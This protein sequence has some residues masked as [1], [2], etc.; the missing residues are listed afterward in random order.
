MIPFML[1]SSF[2]CVCVS[3]FVK[4][5]FS[6]SLFPSQVRALWRSLW[7]ILWGLLFCGP[8]PSAS[9]PGG[10]TLIRSHPSSAGPSTH[11]GTT[12]QQN[13]W[14][15]RAWRHLSSLTGKSGWDVRGGLKFAYFVTFFTLLR[16]CKRIEGTVEQ[17]STG[18]S[19]CNLIF[20]IS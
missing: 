7:G 8:L 18:I 10:P 9:P 13:K 16:C 1:Y 6:S 14:A 17:H 3:L 20:N 2:F 15:R 12:S 4:R 5:L 19:A 11:W